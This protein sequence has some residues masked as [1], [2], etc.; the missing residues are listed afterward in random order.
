MIGMTGAHPE[1]AISIVNATIS[2]IDKMIVGAIA[3]AVAVL[4]RRALRP[5]PRLEA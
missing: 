1:V 3:Y 2:L 5:A 4:V